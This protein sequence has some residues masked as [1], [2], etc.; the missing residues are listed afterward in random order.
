MHHR[1]GQRNKDWT[2]FVLMGLAALVNLLRGSRGRRRGSLFD[3]WR[4]VR[5]PASPFRPVVTLV[6][7]VGAFIALGGLLTV[8]SL[9]AA[10]GNGGALFVLCG[11]PVLLVAFM[12]WLFTQRARQAQNTSSEPGEPG[13]IDA[14]PG[15]VRPADQAGPKPQQADS[16]PV[17]AATRLPPI[18]GRVGAG[19]RRSGQAATVRERPPS[20]P[21]QYRQRAVSYRRKIQSLIKNRRPGPIAERMNGVFQKLK[22]WEERVGQLADRLAL[23]ENDELIQRDVRE[24]P[25]HIARLQRQLS[26]ETEPEMQQQVRRTLA[27]YEEQMRQL[28]LLAR[29]MKRTRLNLDDTLAAMGTV[30]SQLQVLNAMDIDG[31]TAARISDDVD[32]EVDRL[33]DLLA[34][35][36]D[37]YATS[38][39][40]G[41][42]P[43]ADLDDGN[44]GLDGRKARLSGNASG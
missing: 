40:T 9:I 22:S 7:L 5:R 18:A 21:A 39:E 35:M 23:Y 24:T 41:G 43:A 29:V 25:G 32:R 26:Q 15:E 13:T 31:P 10:L 20:T 11:V 19:T 36:S 28:E 12:A 6:M 27:A 38:G 44:A 34:A 42:Q 30:Y 37:V 33:N 3:E 1:N 14:M 2:P 17:P 8:L 4:T 16:T